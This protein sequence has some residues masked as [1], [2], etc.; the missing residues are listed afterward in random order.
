MNHLRIIGAG[1]LVALVA[2]GSATRALA[3]AAPTVGSAPAPALVSLVA[4]ALQ[5]SPVVHAAASRTEAARA[6]VGPAGALPDPMLMAGLMNQ[7]LHGG[8]EASMMTMKTIGISQMLPFPGKRALRTAAAQ[9]ER[10]AAAA[11]LTAARNE[12]T[13]KVKEAYFDLAFLDRSLEV[14]QRNRQLLTSFAHATEARYG[15]GTGTQAEVLQARVE[16]TRLADDATALAAKRSASLAR[17]NA[18]LDQPSATP[19]EGAAIPEPMVRLATAGA[20]AV[21]FSSAALSSSLAG[22]PLPSLATLQA[23]ARRSSP[24]LLAQR[25]RV[26]AQAARVELARKATLPDFDLSLQYGQRTGLSDVVSATVSVPLP[27]HR[28]S[29][30]EEEVKGALATMNALQAEERA[31]ADELDARV[32]SAYAEL[33]RGRTQ[34]ALYARSVL[35]QSRAALESATAGFQVDRVGFLSLLESQATLYNYETQ[36]YRAL[37][38]FAATA[39]ELERLVGK[40]IF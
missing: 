36:Y 4:L 10:A 16:L 20:E 8:G 31:R 39:A 33:E 14:L 12:V 7:P 28:G 35:P 27:L 2:A 23:Q 21:R 34:L 26:A 18:V 32:A 13:A 25:A 30:Q 15:V 6:A 1:L 37:R 9:Q 29:R 40:E 19:L 22:S 3:Q 17:L 24:E 11:E 38:D 5:R